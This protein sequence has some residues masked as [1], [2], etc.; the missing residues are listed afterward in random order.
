MR[1]SLALPAS[2]VGLGYRNIASRREKLILP[3]LCEVAAGTFLMGSDRARDPLA[4]DDELPQCEIPVATFEIGRFPVTVAE[5]ACAV[6]AHA[7]S[8]PWDW[9]Y[10]VDYPDHPVVNV[11]W[12]D[13]ATYGAWLADITE[14]PW[15]LPTEAEWEKAARSTDGRIYPWGDIWLP[16]LAWTLESDWMQGKGPHPIG[17][18]PSG[19]SPYG[20][21]D[22]AGN[23]WEWVSSLLYPYPFDPTDGREDPTDFTGYKDFRGGRGARVARGGAWTYA[24]GRLWARTAARFAHFPARNSEGFIGFRLVRGEANRSHQHNV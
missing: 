19:A 17:I 12:A 5:Y 21:Q 3:P 13:A 10:Q 22:M 15:R 23:V 20:A 16:E 18:R 9:K 8:A 14:Q 6:K 1:R 7:V 24:E 2:L 11:A 4:R